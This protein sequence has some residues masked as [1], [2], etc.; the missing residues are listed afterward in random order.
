MY[1][2]HMVLIRYPLH[3]GTVL[4]AVQLQPPVCVENYMHCNGG[5]NDQFKSDSEEYIK[6]NRIMG[7]QYYM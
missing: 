5:S 6:V 2:L 7:Q 1:P 4:I 3:T